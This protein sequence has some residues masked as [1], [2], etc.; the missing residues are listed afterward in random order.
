MSRVRAAR[1]TATHEALATATMNWGAPAEGPASRPLD[2]YVVRH[3][4]AHVLHAG[5]RDD[6]TARLLD[7]SYMAAVVDEHATFVEP[8]AMWRAVGLERIDGYER[9]AEALPKGE[10]ATAALIDAGATVASFLRDAGRYGAAAALAP[11]VLEASER[12]FGPEHPSTL[13]SVNNLAMLLKARG[14]LDE[15]EPL[16]RR[17]LEARA[18][19]LLLRA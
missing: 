5:R 13:V 1:I 15:A 12:T 10:D 2:A 4:I 16:F 18:V 6:A 3:G 14:K 8:L 9:V 19:C 11:W 7:L 17:A